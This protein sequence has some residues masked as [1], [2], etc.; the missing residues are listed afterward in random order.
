MTPQPPHPQSG[1]P[2]P[3]SKQLYVAWV[4]FQRRAASMGQ[5]LDF[6]IAYVPPPVF[7]R[8]LKPFGY[9]V[10][11][12]RTGR[13]VLSTRP[14]V[15]WLQSP[16]SF[17]PQLLLI[18][19]SF[20]P[21]FRIVVD[22]HNSTFASPWSYFPGAVRAM[23]HC[24]LVLVH[25]AEVRALAVAAGIEA[26]R[27]Q[28]LEDPPSRLASQGRGSVLSEPPYILV[29]CSFRPDEPIP[30]LLDAARLLPEIGFRI[31][32]SRRRAEALGFTAAAPDNVRFTDYLPTTEFER[33]LADAAVVL[34]LTSRE[35]IQL[36]VANEALGAGRALVLS[37]TRILRT[38][39][40]EAALFA[41]N[42][43]ESLAATLREAAAR[44]EELQARSAALKARRQQRWLVEA[45]RVMRLLR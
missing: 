34:G 7:A 24:D 9:L 39:F 15:V 27:L 2:H 16:P 12:A 31:T 10:Q 22:A 45:D 28:V 37:D 21:R 26:G 43:P 29:P 32:G 8:W 1:E 5:F 40:G 17:L 19:R 35:G 36:S 38:L 23:N 4:D 11:A 44:G 33:T 41:R 13:R 6:E 3:A 30:V 25:N 18:L 42:T 20:T 14:D